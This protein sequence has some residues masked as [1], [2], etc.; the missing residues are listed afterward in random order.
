M[1]RHRSYR[2]RVE[3]LESR[4]L[5]NRDP[6]PAL[7]SL[8][9]APATLYLDFDGHF[10]AE[11][12]SRSN[13]YTPA[14]DNDGNPPRSAPPSWSIQT[15]WGAIA[16]D[17]APFNLNV[18]TVAPTS[19][20]NGVGLRVAIGGNSAWT[21]GTV[22]GLSYI[23]S[24]TNTLVNTVYIFSENLGGDPRA[25]ADAAA[26]ESG[27]AFGL[28]HQRLWNGT[29]KIAEY[30]TGPGDGTAPLLGDSYAATRSMWWYGTTSSASTFQDDM[31]VIAGASN[32]FGYRPDDHG[33][34]TGTATS[35]AVAA[36]GLFTAGGIIG[37]MDDLDYFRF[38]SPG[39]MFT[40]RATVAAFN[41]LDAR[42]ELRDANGNLLAAANP[43]GSFDVAFAYAV[44]A[45]DYYLVV[46]SAGVSSNAA[47]GNYGVDVGQ[48]ALSS[49]AGDLTAATTPA[50]DLPWINTRKNTTFATARR[51]VVNSTPGI[52]FATNLHAAIDVDYYKFR[53]PTG[54]ARATITMD[55]RGLSALMPKLFVYNASLKRVAK[56][57]GGPGTAVT[58]TLSGLRPGKV[59]YIMADGPKGDLFGKG[60]YRLTVQFAPATTA[61]A[62]AASTATGAAA[63]LAL[64]TPIPQGLR[65]HH[66]HAHSENRALNVWTLT[67]SASR[68]NAASAWR[69]RFAAAP[70]ALPINVERQSPAAPDSGLEIQAAAKCRCGA[71]ACCACS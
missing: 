30:Q 24:F 58:V 68:P 47:A 61:L 46:A 65:Q 56:K 45:G 44:S 70:P 5:L 41:N 17:Y 37:R 57:N 10:E 8:P 71:C 20:D 63:A 60:A 29:T 39:G 38:S 18:S 23:N 50:G 6:V 27:H 36:D 53:V 55:S 16:E 12:G 51:L 15:I 49:A 9:G 40:F 59:F 11:W 52:S 69:R 35:L 21:G 1:A 25:I 19:F 32:G 28:A 4:L 22:G 34:A 67:G 3:L 2:P 66:S 54:A 7:S 42:L 14:Y 33:D 26:H 13:V 48:Y 62:A 43:A 31:G 64:T